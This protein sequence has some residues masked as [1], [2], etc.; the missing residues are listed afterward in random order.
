M[1]AD[2]TGASEEASETTDLFA[3]QAN[4]ATWSATILAALCI[5]WIVAKCLWRMIQGVDEADQHISNAWYWLAVAT[6]VPL[7]FLEKFVVT[8]YICTT[9]A[10][11]S[12]DGEEKKSAHVS[13]AKIMAICRS[14]KA[15]LMFAFVSLSIVRCSGFMCGMAV[16]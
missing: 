12:D 1:N 14:D 13:I 2:N 8:Q 6:G 3:P 10:T 15:A 11:A 7:L 16:L 9:E 4:K 5:A